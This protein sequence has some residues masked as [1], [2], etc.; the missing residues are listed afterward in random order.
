MYRRTLE[1]H[2]N[3]LMNDFEKTY[4]VMD[5]ANVPVSELQKWYNIRSHR[6]KSAFTEEGKALQGLEQE[7][8]VFALT[9]KINDFT[10][11]KA[12]ETE[13][14][15]LK[16][17]FI[18]LGVSMM[19]LFFLLPMV[20]LES[21]LIR[22]FLAVVGFAVGFLWQLNQVN[23]E[24]ANRREQITEAYRNQLET[25]LQKLLYLCDRFGQER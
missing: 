23:A 12:E 25:H 16:N 22:F 19:G 7:E 21:L 18:L 24:A 11:C 5:I 6:F 13:T 1:K 15:G 4:C 20:G 3:S 9:E 17:R 14:V 10:F 8:L 2:W